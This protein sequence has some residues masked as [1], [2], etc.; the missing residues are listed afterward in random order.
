MTV[1][2]VFVAPLAEIVSGV[3]YVPA[4]IPTELMLRTIDPAP[5]PLETLGVS[6]GAFSETDQLRVPAPVLLSAS[7]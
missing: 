1:C 7:V 2:G 5:V 3:L 6:Q 4:D